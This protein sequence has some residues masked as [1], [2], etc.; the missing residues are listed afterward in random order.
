ML[1]LFEVEGFK[2]FIEPITLDFSDIR[3]YKYNNMCITDG[4]IGKM[5]IYGKNAIGKTNFG[6]ALFDIVPSARRTVSNQPFNDDPVDTSYLNTNNR[7]GYARFRYV[8]RFGDRQVEYNY[9]RNAQQILVYEKIQIDDAL[10]FEFDR[11]HPN[12]FDAVGIKK[13]SPTLNLDFGGVDS[14]FRY[15]VLNTPLK[16]ED[17]L[18]R[19]MN[20]LSEMRLSRNI[21][22]NTGLSTGRWL[23]KT[24]TETGVL[25]EFG[26]FLHDAGIQ[27]NLIAIPDADGRDRLYFDTNPPLLFEQVASSGTK[28]LMD[29]FLLQKTAGTE[30]I[31]LLYLDEFDAFYHFELAESIVSTLEELKDTQI[32]FTSHN[33][34][35]LS[36][37]IMRPD[38]YFIL[39]KNKLTSFA[40]ATSREL[41]EGHNLEKLF[42][43]GEFDE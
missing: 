11:E 37:R 38:C 10:L 24:L 26:E 20:F 39:S 33:T 22:G 5:I 1:R 6:L 43:S 18:R 4:L 15:V 2:N 40:N 8:F 29:L 32:I 23:P 27:E 42:I 17:P 34:N 12:D 25:K 31:S 36:N 19:T 21:Y 35:L 30:R 14:V 3:D 13:I 28:M 41:R 9:R 7:N 16:S